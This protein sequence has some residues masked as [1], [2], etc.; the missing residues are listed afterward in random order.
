V[1]AVIKPSVKER[2]LR[3]AADER[4]AIVEGLYRFLAVKR[5]P[6][7]VPGLEFHICS[8]DGYSLV[9]RE[10]SHTELTKYGENFGYLVFDLRCDA[11]WIKDQLGG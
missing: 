7:R 3:L 11:G 4:Q 5:R 9:C 10:L 1:Y 8:I 2:L 6:F